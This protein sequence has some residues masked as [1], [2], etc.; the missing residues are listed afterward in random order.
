MRFEKISK[1]AALKFCEKNGYPVSSIDFD[2]LPPPE[3]FNG[4]GERL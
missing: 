4:P 1:E 3:A 2:N